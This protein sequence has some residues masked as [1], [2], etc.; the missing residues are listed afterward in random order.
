MTLSN[1]RPQ[2]RVLDPAMPRYQS[3]LKNDSDTFRMKSG[4]VCLQPGESVGEHLTD[5][6]EEVIVI[7][8]GQARVTCEGGDPLA[9]T[10]PAVVYIPPQRRHDVHNVGRDVLRYVYAVTMLDQ[11]GSSAAEKKEAK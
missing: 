1:R 8:S 7:L 6:R 3:L 5:K 2:V 11:E 4:C 10:G 9:A